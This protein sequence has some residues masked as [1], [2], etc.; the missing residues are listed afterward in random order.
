MIKYGGVRCHA[1]GPFRAGRALGGQL[2]HSL[3]RNP[4]TKEEACLALGHTGKRRRTRTW[5]S[6]L[7][8]FFSPPNMDMSFWKSVFPF[9]LEWLASLPL[10]DRE[11]PL[12]FQQRKARSPRQGAKELEIALRCKRLIC[13][14]V[15]T[16]SLDT[17]GRRS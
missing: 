16:V 3:M 7:Y 14:P 13:N 4:G 6:W 8:V 17:D 12:L 9:A 5:S 2:A 15:E 1:E 10:I 11:Q